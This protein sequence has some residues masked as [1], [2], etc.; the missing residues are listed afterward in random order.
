MHAGAVLL[1]VQLRVRLVL[2]ASDCISGTRE[3]ERALFEVCQYLVHSFSA[4]EII[5][6]KKHLF[7]VII[8][9]IVITATTTTTSIIITFV[10]HALA[11]RVLHSGKKQN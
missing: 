5:S 11:W 4:D 1:C 2:A 8:I 3:T 9:I 7:C 6:Q 10:L